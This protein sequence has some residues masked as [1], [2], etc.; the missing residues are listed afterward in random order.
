MKTIET[1]YSYIK[2]PSGI[3]GS[4]SLYET[5]LTL[6]HPFYGEK[7]RFELLYQNWINYSDA[8][9][10]KLNIVIADDCGT[11]SIASLMTPSY[12]KRCDFNLDIFRITKDL[13]YNTPGALNLGVLAAKTEWCLIMDSD[14][15]FDPEA[16]HQVMSIKPDF[17]HVYKFS[18]NRVTENPEWAKNTRYLPCTL[19]FNKDDFLSVTGYDEDFTGEWSHGYGFFDNHFDDK[20]SGRGL[21]FRIIT[22]ILATE[23]MDDVVG[24]RVERNSNHHAINKKLLYEKERNSTNN[25]HI[26]RFPWERTFH[27]RRA[28]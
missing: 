19:L 12:A 15:T 28:K 26:L 16:M 9:K 20:L 13:R 11:P 18:R 3:T 21:H 10:D 22:Y 8:I 27:N 6:I 23:Y 17:N 7:K 1:R 5:G 25:H 24:A 14:C 4:K 2:D